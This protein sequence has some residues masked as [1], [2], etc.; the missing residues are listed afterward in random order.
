L[1][2]SLACAF[3]DDHWAGIFLEDI[4]LAK[5]NIIVEGFVFM[6]EF[7]EQHPKTVDIFFRVGSL[8]YLFASFEDFRGTPHGHVSIL[9]ESAC[10]LVKWAQLQ[11]A[12]SNSTCS[13]GSSIV[14][15][16]YKDIVRREMTMH[17]GRVEGMESIQ[18]LGKRQGDLILVLKVQVPPQL[19]TV[20]TV[21]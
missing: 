3:S 6:P 10:I 16:L 14:L 21:Q 2:L 15:E 13:L 1:E 12:D 5:G 20:L 18:Y 9:V 17:Q 8:S 4:L 19:S 11:I 7:P